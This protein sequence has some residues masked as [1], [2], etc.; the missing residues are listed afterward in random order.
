MNL[1]IKSSNSL[2]SY[3]LLLL[4]YILLLSFGYLYVTL[5]NPSLSLGDIVILLTVFSIIALI[6]L[7]IFFKGETK[8]ADSQTLHILVAVSLKFL[9]EIIFALIWFIVIKKT[10]LPS[11]LMFFVLYLT[12]TLFSL[13][14]MLITLKNKALQNLN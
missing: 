7:I 10:G 3:L 12:L 4:L 11:V 9:L 8:E 14:V 6:T 5:V 1:D 2:S 13:G